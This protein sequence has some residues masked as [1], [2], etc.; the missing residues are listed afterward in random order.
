MAAP[1]AREN[2]SISSSLSDDNVYFVGDL[3]ARGPDSVRR[4]Q[5]GARGPRSERARQSRSPGLTGAT[6]GCPGTP[7]PV[8][9]SEAL[10][11]D[12]GEADWALLDALPLYLDV[13]EHAAILVH[14]SVLPG[15]SFRK[16]DAWTLTHIRS[17]GADGTAPG[18]LSGT[19]S[20]AAAYRG[21]MHVVFSNT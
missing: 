4:A 1:R 21:K 2:Y 9:A 15:I 16:Q 14:A 8:G 20:W 10:L 13:A 19:E 6:R 5:A 7:L 18:H 12:L 17:I 11:R 3:V